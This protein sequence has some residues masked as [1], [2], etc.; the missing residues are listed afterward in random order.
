MTY[1]DQQLLDV[2]FKCSSLAQILALLGLVPAGG[3]YKC[4]KRRISSLGIDTSHLTGRPLV[5]APRARASLEEL[6]QKGRPTNSSQLKARLLKEGLFKAECTVCLTSVWQ[7]KPVP[8]ELEHI[9]GDPDNNELGNLTILCYNCHGQ[10]PTFRGRNKKPKDK[11]TDSQAKKQREQEA[12]SKRL[13]PCDICSKPVSYRSSL[14]KSCFDSNRVEKIH[15][16]S[17]SELSILVQ[18]T[19]VGEVA[20]KLGVSKSSVRSRLSV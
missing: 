3:N 1:T 6:L 4:L 9:D 18:E 14:C 10:T 16:P 20:K 19:S 12:R 2:V 11:T 5:T 15:W 17:S 8:L 7:G 13:K